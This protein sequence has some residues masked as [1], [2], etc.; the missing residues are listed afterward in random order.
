MLTKH[1]NITG[2]FNGVE[3]LKSNKKQFVGVFKCLDHD[4]MAGSRFCMSKD[5][6]LT[7]SLLSA[8][9]FA[10]LDGWTKVFKTLDF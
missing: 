10:P 2:Q 8:A 6:N 5:I 4:Q 1:A 7:N 9:R 3:H